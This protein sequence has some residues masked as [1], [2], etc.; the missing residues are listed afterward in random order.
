MKKLRKIPSSKSS[1]IRITLLTGEREEE[2]NT[3]SMKRTRDQAL[4]REESSGALLLDEAV[5]VDKA[6]VEAVI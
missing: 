1:G 5:A 2:R 6:E 3:L 4:Q